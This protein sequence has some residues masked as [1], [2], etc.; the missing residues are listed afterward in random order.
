[1]PSSP[2]PNP[3]HPRFRLRL[4]L[5]LRAPIQERSKLAGRRALP[6][7][8]LALATALPLAPRAAWSV[9][10]VFELLALPG[11]TDAEHTHVQG[12]HVST[13]QAVDGT[14]L[15]FG[16]SSRFLSGLEWPYWNG[17]TGWVYDPNT[18]VT[19][20]AGLDAVPYAPVD[21][22]CN[23]GVFETT[24]LGFA[25]GS[26]SCASPIY[27][28]A[29]DSHD[30]T[31]TLVGLSGPDY[32]NP[33]DGRPLHQLLPYS[34]GRISSSG[35][36]A[37]STTRWQPTYGNAAWIYD[38]A[39]RQTTRIGFFDAQH[40]AGDGAQSS[41]PAL[42]S[43]AGNVAGYSE[44]YDAGASASYSQ[45]IH[46]PATGVTRRVGFYDGDGRGS[47]GFTRADGHQESATFA[48]TDSAYAA[49]ISRR[50]QG[51]SDFGFV[52]WRYGIADDSMLA[53]GLT[54]PAHTRADG[55]RE[56]GVSFAS[57][58]GHVL[59]SST[60]FDGGP[61]PLSTTPW[62]FDGASLSTTAI[63]L[64]DAAH[65]SA[66]G[67]HQNM[68]HDLT[69]SGF[70][71]GSASRLGIS[72]PP[73][74]SSQGMSV[75]VARTG[76]A[77]ATRIGLV[78]SATLG[79]ATF[80]SSDGEQESGFQALLESGD[81]IGGSVA[82]LADQR[83]G[84]AS[85]LYDASAGTTRPLGLYGPRFTAPDGS[86]SSG[87]TH[88]TETGFIAGY[89]LAADQ[90]RVQWVYSTQTDEMKEIAP[91]GAPDP[92]VPVLPEVLFLT[93]SGMVLG[94]FTFFDGTPPNWTT[95]RY[96][97]WTP[98]GGTIYLDERIDDGFEEAGWVA[99][100]SIESVSGDRILG[101]GRRANGDV[102]GLMLVGVPEPSF[103]TLVSIGC[104]AVAWRG[105][106]RHPGLV[107]DRSGVGPSGH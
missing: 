75:W 43:A 37:G 5:R 49:G 48:L 57:E 101:S 100:E 27:F 78:D 20:R 54:D 35:H 55:A 61:D 65:T 72:V 42:L 16:S 88:W 29:F 30:R 34:E 11:L 46:R 28:W 66:E 38:S 24:D 1:M 98:E 9:Q 23:N 77:G 52:A 21:Q 32:A 6:A 31:R 69:E 40:T 87:A 53:L 105:A 94:R 58:S 96:F 97:A 18:G 102:D 106:R 33:F 26:T 25:L 50:F 47:T 12:V 8:L 56:S 71:A 41:F 82:F 84:V 63:G 59:G 73:T 44:R 89:S 60:R 80:T 51:A 81:V 99:I 86:F 4:S 13:A 15:V 107:V 7:F 19:S 92:A 103:A 64:F 90:S 17:E 79:A 68:H 104:L 39:T 14:G 91:P 74:S 76:V 93:D 70:A 62:L 10:P 85:W 83:I 36:I 45:W 95:Q 22:Y 2:T 67:L 3:L